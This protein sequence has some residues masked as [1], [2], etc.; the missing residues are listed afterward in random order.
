MKVVTARMAATKWVRQNA[1][2][3]SWFLGA[4]FS[5]STV[6]LPDHT[7]LSAS[8]DIDIVIVVDEDE[9]PLKLGKFEYEGVLIEVTYLTFKQLESTEEV[10]TNYHLAGSFRIDSI[11]SDPTGYLRKLQ[12]EVSEHFADIEWVRRRCQNAHA[13]I[14]QGLQAIDLSAPLYDR[15]TS[16][17][18]PTGVTTHLLL[19]ASL[20][21]PTVRLRYLAA[22][23]VL[24]EYTHPDVYPKLLDLLGCSHLTPTRIEY[25]VEQLARTFDAATSVAHT[26]F[27]F[28]TDITKAARPIVIDGS[29]HL[30]RGGFHL[31]AVFWIVA[32]FARC[33]KILAADASPIIQLEH[34]S[35]FEELIS[36][37]GISS[38]KVLLDRSE[39][40][41]RYL[42]TLWDV[43]EDIMLA[44]PNIRNK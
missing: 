14:E 27:F 29:L 20:Q 17:L 24:N 26:P 40:V 5:G 33:H 9:P 39:Q 1:S 4:Y 10:L 28:S 18:F 7:E 19:V 25:H 34:I 43:A 3:E 38:G 8:S 41:K 6:G 37:L 31:E 36:D 22:R 23:H 15:I 13:K 2:L 30:I 42:P 12:T 16:W 32:T 35:A 44:N 11:I 21:N